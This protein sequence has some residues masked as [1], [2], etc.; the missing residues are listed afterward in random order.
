MNI[1]TRENNRLILVKK[2]FDFYCQR[3]EER[4]RKSINGKDITIRGLLLEACQDEPNPENCSAK[5]AL[6]RLQNFLDEPDEDEEKVSHGKTRNCNIGKD[7]ITHV[8]P[9]CADYVDV[10]CMY[11][12]QM[13]R[14]HETS[15]EGS[16]ICNCF[17]DDECED[18]YAATL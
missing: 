6:E 10:P 16:G 7:T 12:G 9:N 11:C 4:G 1:E 17:C 15:L 8:D 13:H 2:A 3:M 18:K 14:L 5:K